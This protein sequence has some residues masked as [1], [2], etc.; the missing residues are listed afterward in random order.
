LLTYF[1]PD[2]PGSIDH[3]NVGTI[4]HINTVHKNRNNLKNKPLRKLKIRNLNCVSRTGKS[5]RRIQNWNWNWNTSQWQGARRTTDVIDV[6]RSVLLITVNL[7]GC[8]AV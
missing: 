3:R 1:E 8:D 6:S 2:D 4:A 5:T 7:L